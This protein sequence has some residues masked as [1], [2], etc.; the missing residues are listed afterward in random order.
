MNGLLGVKLS[1]LEENI[2]KASVILI[3]PE[4]K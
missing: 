4:I 2:I 1:R 3:N